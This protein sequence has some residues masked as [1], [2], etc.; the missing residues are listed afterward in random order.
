MAGAAAGAGAGFGLA[1][2]LGVSSSSMQCKITQKAWIWP[3]NQPSK[4][5]QMFKHTEQPQPR[6]KKTAKGGRKMAQ[7]I[8]Q[9]SIKVTAI[10]VLL[11]VE[12]GVCGCLW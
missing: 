4:V 11:L 8:L 5:K 2:A 3:G 12:D 1:G 9:M 6:S 7:K 10:F